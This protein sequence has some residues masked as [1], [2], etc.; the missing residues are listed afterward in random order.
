MSTERG[1]VL[2]FNQRLFEEAAEHARSYVTS[3]HISC[4]LAAVADREQILGVRAWNERG[5]EDASLHSGIFAL[6]SI[7]K[8]IVSVGIARLVDQGVLDYT[9]PVCRHLPEFGEVAW[10]RPITVGDIFTHSTGLPAFAWDALLDLDLS[11]ETA[12]LRLFEGDALYEPRTRFQYATFTYQLLNAIVARRLGKGMS[13][14]LEETV[15]APCGM[16]DTGYNPVDPA[17]A[18]PVP[19][20]P[21]D[22]PE[23]LRRFGDLELSGAGLWSSAPDLIRLG[24]A[25]LAQ[26]KILSTE[27]FRRHT[28]AQPALP[29]AAGEGRSRR[30]WG[31][32]KEP[33]ARF[34][35]QSETGFYHGGAPGTLLWVDPARDLV[36]VFLTTR[37]GSG[38]DHAFATL[39]LLYA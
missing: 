29:C 16:A 39:N 5:E 31:W 32:N 21:S 1:V 26:G 2:Q 3:G 25:L 4:A 36:F 34:P 35:R 37:W 22:T 23:K 28:E 17:R 7:T 14:F 24:Q 10:R 27:G 8:A 19:G 38:N 20:H 9:D 18:M 33:Q 13:R 6:A 30:T 12:Y 15:Y 11:G